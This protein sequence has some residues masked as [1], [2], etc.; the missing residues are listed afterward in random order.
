MQKIKGW[1][2]K[3]KNITLILMV[4]FLFMV[5]YMIGEGSYRKYILGEDIN[6]LRL[7]C[8]NPMLY[9]CEELNIA[10]EYCNKSR[11]EFEKRCLGYG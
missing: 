10:K 5:V 11:I 1:L 8:E 7:V 6:K 9:D 4:V 3:E 2:K